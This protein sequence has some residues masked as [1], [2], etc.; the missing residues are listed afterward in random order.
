MENLWREELTEFGV[1]YVDLFVKLG[2]IKV[3]EPSLDGAFSKC[4]ERSIGLRNSGD[5]Q[6]RL[7]NISSAMDYY[8]QS[9]CFA[10]IESENCALAYASRSACFF[11]YKKYDET[12][13]DIE[14][15]KSACIPEHML[16]Q[17]EC[18]KQ[19][20]RELITADKQRSK[21]IPKL[22][23]KTNENFRCVAECL[24]LQHNNEFGRY[25]SAKCDIP[26][27]RIVLAE[28]SFIGVRKTNTPL[29]CYN[30]LQMNMNF[31]AC[32]ICSAVVF[33]SQKC[34]DANITH[35][36]E[37]GT[38]FNT[39]DC[40]IRFQAQ[41]V[42]MAIEAFVGDI[43]LLI[44]F[45]QGI[46]WH[47]YIPTSLH[48]ATSKY[49]FFFQLSKSQP[50]TEDIFLVFKIYSDLMS[51][52][53]IIALFD[54]PEKQRFLKHLVAHHFLVIL[55]NSHGSDSYESIGNVFSMFNHSCAPNLMQ[56][57]AGKQH[58]VTIRPVKKGDQLFISYLGKRKLS[59]QK[60]QDKLQSN[61]NFICRCIRCVSTDIDFDQKIVT[62]DPHFRFIFENCYVEKK[63]IEI[64][65][66]CC[67]FL[68]KYGNSPWSEEIQF[69][70]DIYCAY[71]VKNSL[72]SI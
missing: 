60:R 32:H 11:Q 61:W 36:Y 21:N 66:N 70:V 50:T 16:S 27:G 71:L 72:N 69:I 29:S 6:F 47:P 14:L 18:R 17:L 30:C 43:D 13:I 49:H 15:A 55:N 45:I 62:A 39:F 28:K 8:N 56:Y 34:M 48:D 2:K 24:E 31:I 52:P 57:F 64:L 59:L 33:C 25:F 23:Y 40:E 35:K 5:E 65:E 46:L 41:A 68:N 53:K 37:C 1:Q 63:S 12:L 10:E 7:G 19:K 67:E 51:I 20:C 44:K 22:S 38:P 54:S 58:L 26:V 9:L 42:F 4:N 3:C